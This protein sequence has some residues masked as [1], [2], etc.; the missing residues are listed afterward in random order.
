M[1]YLILILFCACNILG[2]T[3]QESDFV[4][5]IP[6]DDILFWLDASQSHSLNSSGT[7][8]ITWYDQSDNH[9]ALACGAGP[10]AQ[11]FTSS[12]NGLN[13][14]DFPAGVS[15]CSTNI[16]SNGSSNYTL[17]A[18]I[19][20]NNAGTTS[21]MKDT[22]G[23]ALY[24]EINIVSGS[25]GYAYGGGGTL[26]ITNPAIVYERPMIVSFVLSDPNGYIYIDGQLV[27]NNIYVMQDIAGVDMEVGVATLGRIGELLFYK[28]ALTNPE[29]Q[30]IEHYL[31][32]KWQL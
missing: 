11:V 15:P 6:N 29:R 16:S 25:L 32:Q 26:G 18:V 22:P 12:I 19:D 31:Q 21:I 8:L 9:L 14:V 23:T 27:Y 24:F 17:I 1:K 3:E 10:Y 4:F 7:D 2:E 30:F 20:P 5:S 13:S 28:R